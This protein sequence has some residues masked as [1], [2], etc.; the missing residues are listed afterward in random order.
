MA[1][2]IPRRKFTVE[3]YY[4]MAATGILAPDER[5]E[6]I[7]GEIIEMSPIGPRHAH[8]VDQITE[9]IREKLGR[10][11]YLR[12]QN[13]I[14]LSNYTEPEPDITLAKRADYSTRHPVGDDVFLTIEVSD[15]TLEKDRTL[16]QKAYANANIPEFWI[17][18]L[19]EDVVEVYRCP[20]GD[21]YQERKLVSRAESIS[22]QLLP[23]LVLSGEELLG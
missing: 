10:T 13:P 12:A 4:Q 5:V 17:V 22:P 20:V 14:R 2:P 8:C 11:I 3:Q 9:L 21:V 1:T 16:K 7:E 19:P 18:N 15:S 23:N 6:L